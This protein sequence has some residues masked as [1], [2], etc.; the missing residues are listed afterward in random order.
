M[1]AAAPNS[2]LDPFDL[3][4]APTTLRENLEHRRRILER[5]AWDVEFREECWI[6]S[7]RDF[8]WWCNTFG[9]THAIKDRKK[10]P[11]VPFILYPY[12]ERA[13]RDLI[14]AIGNEDRLIEKSR[15]MGATWIVLAVFTW[16][17]IFHEDCSFLVGSRKQEFVDKAGSP[18]TLFYK[19]DFIL[20]KLPGWMRPPIIPKEH[21]TQNHIE[22]PLNGSV[23][24]GESTNE[25]F[26]A[27]DRRTAVFL[28]EFA[29]VVEMGY[30]ILG[31]VQD[32]TNCCIY[33]ST[34]MGAAGAYFDTRQMMAER[35]PHQILRFHWSDHPIKRRGLY[36]SIKGSDGAFLLEIQDKAYKFPENYQFILDGKQRSIAYDIRW[37][38]AVNKQIIAQQ[39]DIDYLMSGFQF[40]DTVKLAA[41]IEEMARDPRR[42][43]ELTVDPE[44]QLPRWTT[45]GGGKLMLWVDLP[46]DG[47]IPWN[48]IVIGADIAS[49]SGG[50]QSSN[51]SAS[52][53]RISTG[54]KIGELTDNQI[55]PT[56]FA[57]YC[58]RL[59]RWF[60][61]A[62]LIWER[63]GP[64]GAQFGKVV[65]DSGYRY[66]YYQRS[67]TRFD[68]IRSKEPGWWTDADSKPAL[69]GQYA[70]ALFDRKF[71]NPSREALK[72]CGQY[73]QKGVK[74]E[75]SRSLA[76]STEDETATGEAHGDRVIADA[77][78]YRAIRD[79]GNPVRREPE[80]K[81]PVDC[82]E[83]RRKA[84]MRAAREDDDRLW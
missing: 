39:W 46:A 5:C 44:T 68:N 36:T 76:G 56:E 40:F 47:K 71:R 4:P 3:K 73:V 43:G 45:H 26:G 72:E 10:F 81:V 58:L 29:L 9:W 60:N 7:K 22:N 50:E 28:D 21:R 54:E 27:G 1:V 78:V 18:K 64:N 33:N 51:S 70:Q 25:N 24:D 35:S 38:R 17:F 57:T 61:N 52:I 82:A 19:I 16:F 20:D 2:D 11:K 23:I 79:H 74:I 34:P 31:A 77:L 48:D 63:N 69:L 30:R 66:V 8:V 41:A 32:V 55:N 83:N 53:A 75:H 37:K 49:G 80:L 15:D 13:A 59:C 62:Q 12:Q 6:R 14:K 65:K 67:D 84:R 42:T